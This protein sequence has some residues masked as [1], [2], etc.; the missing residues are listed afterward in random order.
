MSRILGIDPGSQ[1]TGIGII[2]MQGNRLQYIYHTVIR[3]DSKARFE[4]RLFTLFRETKQ[5]IRTYQPSVV[6]MED[7]FVSKN[8]ASAL[9]LGQARGSLIAACAEAELEIFPY[10]PTEVKQAIVGTGRAEKSQVQYMVKMLLGKKE[11][12]QEDAADALAVSICHA[13]HT[14]MHRTTRIRP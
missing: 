9:K 14:P 7:V 3:T 5:L 11:V 10:A 2:D 1:K 8:I 6:A 12:L 13:H 4:A